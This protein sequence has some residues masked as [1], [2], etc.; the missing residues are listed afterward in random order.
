MGNLKV[1]LKMSCGWVLLVTFFYVCA[2]PPVYALTEK[3]EEQYLSA[4]TRGTVSARISAAK[5]VTQSFVRNDKIFIEIEHQLLDSYNDNLGRKHIDQMAWYCKALASSGKEKYL[6]TVR[7]VANRAE[8]PKLQNYARQSVEMFPFH[9]NRNSVLS[10]T[11]EY[12]DQGFDSDSAELAVMLRSDQMIMKRDGAKKIFRSARVAFIDTR[13]FDIVEQELVKGLRV[14]SGDHD[15]YI[16]T[17]AWL[18][19]ALEVSGDRKYLK[20][21]QMVVDKSSSQKLQKYAGQAYD[22]CNH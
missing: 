16:D 20:S 18:C 9:K 10:R 11:A 1:A 12:I 13:L 21:L 3:V 2:L 17:M 5:K 22:E 6:E 7:Q 8:D 14:E 15:T 19:R 4:I